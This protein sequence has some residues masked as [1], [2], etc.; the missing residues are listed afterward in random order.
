MENTRHAIT[1]HET[2]SN[3]RTSPLRVRSGIRAGYAQSE[4]ITLRADTS[5]PRRVARP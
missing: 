3:T 4:E 5:A 2:L 1:S